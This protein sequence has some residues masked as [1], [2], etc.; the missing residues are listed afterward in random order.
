MKKQI[1]RLE[2]ETAIVSGKAQGWGILALVC[3][4]AIL[5]FM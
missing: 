3:I 1:N 2:I 4:V 5:A